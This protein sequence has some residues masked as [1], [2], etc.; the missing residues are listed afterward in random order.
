MRTLRVYSPLLVVAA[1]AIAIKALDP[2]SSP[3]IGALDPWSWTAWARQFL[4]TG[5]LNSFFTQT[6]YPPT[7]MYFIAALASSGTDPY[8]IVRFI[9]IATALNVIPIYLLT[10]EILRSHRV[11]TLASLL[12]VTDRFYFMRTSVGIPEGLAHLF[13]VFSLLFMLRGLV[14][15]R[16]TNLLLAAAFLA[17]SVLYYHFLLIIL[18]PFAVV[19]PFTL[20]LG[21]RYSVKALFT[22]IAPAL[23]FS[24]IVWYIQVLPVMLRYYLGT[25]VYT[26]QVPVLQ[27]SATGFI[28]LLAVSVGKTAAVAMGELGYVLVLFGFVGFAMVVLARRVRKEYG[29]GAGFLMTYLIVLA[30][31]TVALRIVYNLGFAGAGDSSVYMFSWL[32]MP[33]AILAAYAIVVGLDSLQTNLAARPKPIPYKAIVRTLTVLVIIS[34][35]VA[36]LSALNYYKA[37]AAGGMG[38]LQGH[39]YYKA[40]TD[41][42]YYAF[43]YVRH[44][45]AKNALVL[46][47]GVEEPILTYEA[48]AAERTIMGIQNVTVSGQNVTLYAFI[49]YPEL[50]TGNLTR[51]QLKFQ[52]EPPEPIYLITGIRKVN[53]D[54]ARMDG[55]P[56]LNTV[57][58]GALLLNTIRN[59]GQYEQ[60]YQNEQVSV[61]KVLT[62]QLEY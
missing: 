22:I 26:Y 61:F 51:I 11:A 5:T 56:P 6:G 53:L 25:K 52:G 13:F 62:G 50:H 29:A 38:I 46:A 59:Q 4:S 20:Q 12:T 17:S 39:Y 21:K 37:P 45:S 60:V 36:N 34:L 23:T 33:I 28:R 40:M 41:Q 42:E 7:F 47:V 30:F 1:F 16:W 35:C 55:F 8:Q 10:L 44:N 14:T 32:A 19:L 58:M 3:V 24:A 48:I 43:D 27:R 57:S 15:K 31:L 54:V 9:P 2:I 49:A 18:I